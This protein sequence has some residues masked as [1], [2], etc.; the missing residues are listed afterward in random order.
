MKRVGHL[1]DELLSMRIATQAIYKGTENK[2]QDHAVRRLLGYDDNVPEHR[3]KLDPEKVNRYAHKLIE[4]L[5]S[6]WVPAPMRHMTIK[7]LRGKS[8]EINCPTL[9]DHIIHWMLILT[10]KPVIMRG[11]YEH[12]YGSIP[13]RGI[14]GAR[15]AVERWVQHDDRAKYF[16]KLDI[17][18]FYQHVDHE[19]LVMLF[20]STIKDPFIIDIISRVLQSIPDGLP[21]GAYTSQWFANFYLQTL[22]HHIAQGLFK[23]RRGKRI[24]L[25]THHCRYMDD[26]LL[27]GSSKRDL[28]KAVRDIMTFATDNLHI[29]IKDCWEVR[30]IAKND[31]D[32]GAGIAP[33]DIVGYRFYRDHTEVRSSIFLHTSRIA[34]RIA[35]RLENN[36][37][38]LLHDAQSI[39]SL[40]GWF[41]HADSEYFYQHYINNRI[42]IKFMQEVISYASKNGIVGDAARIYC[43]KRGE[44]GK[45]HILYGRSGG[46]TGRVYRLDCGSVGNGMR[47]DGES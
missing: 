3:G 36:S 26:I 21:I 35:K 15:K 37:I 43:S 41:S 28:E 22:D 25:V 46:K 1:R 17:K 40:C 18:K 13:G 34:A 20:Q 38:V 39:V 23:S 19:K 31:D 47:L 8:R 4:K 5:Q 33:I 11:M 10:I 2:R 7:P 29:K 16:V 12:S 6:G 42:S 30:A 24:N 44:D 9:S 45:Y 27:I 32:V 14:E